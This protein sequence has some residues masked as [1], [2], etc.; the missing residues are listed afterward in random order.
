MSFR[1]DQEFDPITWT[2]ELTRAGADE[3][4]GR[5][6]KSGD[7]RSGNNNGGGS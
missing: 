3:Q 1:P 7:R 6:K 2:G 5:N 4:Q